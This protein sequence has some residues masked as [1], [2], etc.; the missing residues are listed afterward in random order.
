MKSKRFCGLKPY[1]TC[2]LL[3]VSSLSLAASDEPVLTFVTGDME[4]GFYHSPQQTGLIDDLL[5]L[6]LKRMGY[7]LRILTVP[8]ERSLKM[9]AAGY[10]DGEMLRTTAI[11]SH[12]PTLLRVPEKLVD[13]EF[14][15]FSH[16]LVDLNEGWQSLAGKSVGIVIG[17][18]MIENKM[19]ASALVT[20]VKDKKLL[21]TLLKRKR[22][23]HAVFIRD[24]GQ[25]Y[26]Y[27]NNIKGVFVNTMPLDKVS[28]YAY[29]H[30]KH[31]ALVPQLA[32]TLK[33][34]KQ[35]GSFEMLVKQH[36]L[37]TDTVNLERRP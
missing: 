14:V 6:A 31:A 3:L 8:T 4:T 29:L 17:M 23:D 28:G 27:K 25:F 18:K 35:D 12:F 11:E 24:T 32:K 10:A 7:G 26:L 16:K 21:F 22:I 19:P 20:K 33:G 37:P 15:V 36:L 9:T 30:P 34:M 5:G 2:V 13:G 1:M